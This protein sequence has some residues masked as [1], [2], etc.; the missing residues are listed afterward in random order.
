M[1]PS[2][3]PYGITADGGLISNVLD[4]AR[5]LQ[6]MINRGELEEVR[7][8]S[9]ESMAA[10]EEPRVRLPYEVFGGESYGYGGSSY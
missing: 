3:Y 5:Y 8:A 4:L 9:E 1:I 10:M 6:M 7:I 2:T